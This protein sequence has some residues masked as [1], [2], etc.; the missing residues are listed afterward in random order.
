M[1]QQTPDAIVDMA[2]LF[3]GVVLVLVRGIF[4]R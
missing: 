2:A 1:Q 4:G 3:G